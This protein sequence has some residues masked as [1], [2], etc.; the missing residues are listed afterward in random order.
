MRGFIKGGAGE[1]VAAAADLALDI[2]L[3]GLL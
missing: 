2:G 3:A 1:F